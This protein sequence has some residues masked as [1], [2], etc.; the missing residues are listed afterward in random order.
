MDCNFTHFCGKD[1]TLGY[2]I[3]KSEFVFWLKKPENHW[4]H[5]A[6]GIPKLHC[7]LAMNEICCGF[8]KWLQGRPQG[9]K[10]NC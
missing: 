1:T 9:V 3:A 7:Y 8:A 2:Q 6:M 5:V 10:R 4:P